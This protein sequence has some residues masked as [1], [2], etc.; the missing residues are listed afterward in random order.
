MKKNLMF[1]AV[2]VAAAIILGG[3]SSSN[4]ANEP[5]GTVTKMG[6]I[7]DIQQDINETIEAAG[8]L[9]SSFDA[10]KE[11]FDDHG[12]RLGK[13]LS[14]NHGLR[15]CESGSITVTEQNGTK[16]VSVDK[17]QVKDIEADGDFSYKRTS[18]DSD[19]G[20]IK[21]IS[22]VLPDEAYIKTKD[23]KDK[24]YAKNINF[25]IEA[26]KN[27][28]TS[29]KSVDMNLSIEN[30]GIKAGSKT[31]DVKNVEFFMKL[32]NQVWSYEISGMFD[33][34]KKGWIAVATPEEFKQNNGE[35]CPYDGTLTITGKDH[36]LKF[37]VQNDQS[38]KVY[39][40]DEEIKTYDS[41]EDIFKKQQ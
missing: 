21:S 39:Y 29:S 32:A 38:I 30:G 8:E 20:S 1:G 17:C 23:N 10:L 22:F 25:Y 37:E 16:F 11:I 4:A 6:T 27:Y 40:D 3:C 18:T 15:N 41:C 19:T 9:E 34:N 12:V 33:L 26:K 14:T 13:S 28:V 7:N 35:K 24:V 36:T 31:I 2:A 5:T